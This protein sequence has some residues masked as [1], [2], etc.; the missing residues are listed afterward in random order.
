MKLKLQREFYLRPAIELAPLLLGKTFIR[1]YKKRKLAGLIVETEA[2]G[3]DGD[4]A[5]H[6]FPGKTKRNETMFW[7]GGY[8]YVYFIYGMYFCCNVVAGEKSK[9]EAVLIRALQ[10]IEG[11][12]EM[13]KNRSKVDRK[14]NMDKRT[15]S[16]GPGKICQAMSI[17]LSDNGISLLGEEVYIADE[18]ILGRFEVVK[19]TRV[20]IVKSAD[21]NRRFYIK[22]NPFVSRK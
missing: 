1:M 5:S 8:L 11:I 12:E 3:Y 21:L 18:N 17:D 14:I 6:S 22:D 13:I 20:G 2:Y 4:M 9:G 10:P 19:T 7:E 16:N 15:V